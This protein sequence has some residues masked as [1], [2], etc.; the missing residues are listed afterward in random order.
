MIKK[1]GIALIALLLLGAAAG[2]AAPLCANGT[3]ADY[4]ALG[5]GGCT[6]NGVLFNDFSYSDTLGTDSFYVSGIKG[7][8][9]VQSESIVTVAID[10]LDTGLVFNGNW[11]VN[12]YQTMSLSI[13]FDVS[14]AAS[15]D[16]LES[17]FTSTKSGTQNDGPTSTQSAIC[18]GGTC[19]ATNFTNLTVPITGTTSTLAISNLVTA[20]AQGS[21]TDS[22]NNFHL[23][24]LQDHFG[25]L[26]GDA[27]EPVSTSL[28]GGGMFALLLL[29]KRRK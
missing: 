19:S 21:A 10:S 11:V 7:T 8:G 1:Y 20:N 9:V 15:I 2:S 28:I 4:L 18:N 24:I 25:T 13:G 5:S 3:M 6:I 14:S 17:A 16:Q 27:P 29:R 22:T 23:S 12:H 26:A